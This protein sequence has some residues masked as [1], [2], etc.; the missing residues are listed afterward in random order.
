[1]ALLL[2]PAVSNAEF[3]FV[4]VG[5]SSPYLRPGWP[6]T[7]PGEAF[8]S[9]LI[10]DINNDGLQEIVQMTR[11]QIRHTPMPDTGF[12]VLTAEGRQIHNFNASFLG[13]TEPIQPLGMAFGS[14]SDRAGGELAFKLSDGLYAYSNTT[15][16]PGFPYRASLNENLATDSTAGA[17]ADVDGDG[18]DEIIS[19]GTTSTHAELHVVKSNGQPLP[20]FP[21]RIQH[22]PEQWYS[23]RG[24]AVGDMDGD[25]K[26]EIFVTATM[27]RHYG[28][29]PLWPV[30]SSIYGLNASGAV[31]PGFPFVLTGLGA[32]VDHDILGPSNLII[33]DIDGVMPKELIFGESAKGR[34][35]C[36][37]L[38]RVHVLGMD[39]KEKPGWPFLLPPTT[40]GYG[41]VGMGDVNGDGKPEIVAAMGDTFV[42][43]GD[44]TVDTLIPWYTEI[45]D[46]EG[47]M[48]R[49]TEV[50]DIH[51]V[52]VIDLDGDGKAEVALTGSWFLGPEDNFE[53]FEGIRIY[54]GDTL[55]L[56][57]ASA[58]IPKPLPP[59]RCMYKL[60]MAIVAFAPVFGDVD[61]DGKMEAVLT[62]MRINSDPRTPILLFDLPF[63]ASPA[64]LD[65]PMPQGNAGNTGEYIP[66]S[67]RQKVNVPPVPVASAAPASGTAPLTVAFSGSTSYDPDGNIVS[68]SWRFGDGTTSTQANPSHTYA[69]AGTFT[70]TLTVT[71]NSGAS[72]LRSMTVV[73]KP[74]VPNRLP[75]A[76]AS[77]K[78]LSGT[79]PLLV[80]F[81]SAGSSD[82][83]GRIVSYAWEFGDGAT[84]NQA[85]P[86][87]TYTKAGTFTAKL[88][89]T[90]NLGATAS[91]SLTIT[92]RA[93]TSYA[94]FVNSIDMEALRR[95]TGSYAKATVTVL[96]QSG[97][98]AA[99]ALVTGKWSNGALSMRTADAYGKASFASPTLPGGGTL[100]FTVTEVEKA[101]YK[102][103]ASRNVETSD[104]I[105]LQK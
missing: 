34:G 48:L 100:S 4:D 89:V 96:N 70:A 66:R 79:A 24:L 10:A 28:S 69:A 99:Y 63:N 105:T 25:G 51:G 16:L 61:G 6:A 23:F 47:G 91:R 19:A 20:G 39:G 44:G 53:Y 72:S 73:A 21:F 22:A 62:L 65:W 85:N 90:D 18:V 83:D 59:S 15:A 57:L 52:S 50:L 67:Q 98:P 95:A 35:S 29:G 55:V 3:C 9:P 80:N 7:L 49:Q 40:R 58:S 76:A 103:D 104:S 8:G 33:A 77:A 56:S 94:V 26:K 31:M 32:G 78:P 71:D 82:P 68:F 5:S 88:T 42:L 87:Y 2:L 74:A 41:P 37:A 36:G 75:A 12:H 46:D 13:K 11:T 97:R 101:G 27:W 64:Q 45:F 92:V 84:S 30:A 43:R 60:P 38:A 102:Y 81:S 17:V 93:A 86:S 14:L 54:R 1:V